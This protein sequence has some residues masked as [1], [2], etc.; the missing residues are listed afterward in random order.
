MQPL[1]PNPSWL[2]G[3][4]YDVVH[5]RHRLDGRCVPSVTQAID[6]AYPDRFAH[7]PPAVLAHKAAIGTAVHAAAHY[8]ADGDL[9]E[10]S[11]ATEVQP[12]FNAWKWFSRTRRVEPMLIG[13][14]PQCETVVCSRDLGLAPN[15][16][17]PYVGK[18][19]FLCRVDRQWIVL[20]DLKT[21]VPSL[22]RM[23]TI[24]YLDALYQQYPPLI[25]IDIQRWAVVV[26]SAGA[27]VVHA[28]RDDACDAADF[29]QVLDTAYAATDWR[30]DVNS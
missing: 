12:R 5:R 18:L 28:F 20:L 22:A 2:L 10:S 8:H 25:A 24:A 13:D 17:R 1:T 9:L 7:I 26:T 15:R 30:R 27:Y 23:Q 21:G 29:R 16:R 6:L 3:A 14:V 11:L 4:E 19:D